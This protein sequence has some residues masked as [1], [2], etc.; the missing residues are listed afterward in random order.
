MLPINNRVDQLK[1]NHMFNIIHGQAP[2][3]FYSNFRMTSDLH[4]IHTRSRTLTICIP[5]VNTKHFGQTS[6]LYTGTKIWNALTNEIRSQPVKHHFRR[7]AHNYLF[8]RVAYNENNIF[9]G[10]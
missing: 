9:I 8:D 4:N 1:L 10:S 6:F 7:L 5:S 3:Y 2:A